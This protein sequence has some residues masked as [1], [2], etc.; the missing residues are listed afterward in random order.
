MT[1]FV[2][3]SCIIKNILYSIGGNI[4]GF[5]HMWLNT[6]LFYIIFKEIRKIRLELSHKGKKQNLCENPTLNAIQSLLRSKTKKF[7]LKISSKMFI[8]SS[9]LLKLYTD[10]KK[11]KYKV[12]NLIRFKTMLKNKSKHIN[13][14]FFFHVSHN[15]KN[16]L[17]HILIL[18]LTKILLYTFL[19]YNK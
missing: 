5:R 12:S 10:F 16:D 7:K 8:F 18:C 14:Y 15:N 13:F 6:I 2:D 9:P 17:S 3:N 11:Y 4:F 19:I 1:K